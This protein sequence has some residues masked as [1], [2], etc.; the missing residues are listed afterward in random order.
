VAKTSARAGAALEHASALKQ[1]E[2]QLGAHLGTKVRVRANASRTRGRLM[3]EFYDL[4]HFDGLM[5]RMG[6]HMK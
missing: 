2:E 1:L 6:F 5:L 4:D 3:I